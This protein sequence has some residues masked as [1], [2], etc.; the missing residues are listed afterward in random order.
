MQKRRA[1]DLGAIMAGLF[2]G[3]G[4]GFNK[5]QK[6]N[7]DITKYQLSTEA[8]LLIGNYISDNREEY[9]RLN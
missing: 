1:D 4:V 5:Y 9:K 3:G 8:R 7:S 2:G 6:I